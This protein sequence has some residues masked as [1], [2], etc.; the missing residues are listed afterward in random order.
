MPARIA[1]LPLVVLLMG[2]CAASMWV[3]AAQAVVLRDHGT[4][5]VFFYSGLILLILTGMI[6]I[7]TANRRPRD[8]ARANLTA[9]VGAFGVLPIQM[10]LPM[11]EAV[12]GLGW[13]DAW[14]EMI[15]C[16]TTTGLTVLADPD[17]VAPSVH[18][19]RA[20]VGWM[21]GFLI[22]VAAVAILA[23]MN[24]G[25][26][27]VIS[28]RVPG[29]GTEGLGQITRTADPAQRVRRQSQALL[30]IYGGLTLALW[31]LLTIG[32]DPSQ[33]ALI[34]AMATVSTSGISDGVA[35]ADAGSGRFGEVLVFLVLC[36]ALS[37]RFWP[38]MAVTEGQGPIRRDPELRLAVAL[39]LAIPAILVL[40]HWIAASGGEPVE[41]VLAAWGALFT[42]LSFLTTTGF[43]S[44]DWETAQLWSGLGTPGL[45]LAGLAIMGGGVATTAGGVKLLRV[46]ALVRHGERELER[47]IHPNSVGGAGQSARRLRRE[48]AYLAWVFFMLFALGIAA[49]VAAL[50][51]VAVPFEPAL[52]LTLAALT[53]TGPLADVAGQAPVLAS[54]YGI[55]AKAILG[56]AMVV[57]RLEMLAILALIAP[58]TWRR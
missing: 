18:L 7:A 4:A 30:P 26:M 39:L 56:I 9:L 22:L 52:I 14:F 21:G 37:R 48:G 3:P 8:P 38:G 16:F 51:L 35:L 40:R 31:V 20:M 47:L 44:A 50:T 19:W 13:F 43:L 29:R 27:E 32:G 5:R 55:P 36:V 42:T 58:E 17:A 28:G 33:T 45:V 10:A 23:P 34:R 49:V 1:D 24:L 46:Y 12:P 15:S 11:A 53:T 57:G 54:D 6:A 41:A 2:I 25:G